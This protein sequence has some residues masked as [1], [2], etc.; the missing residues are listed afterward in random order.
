MPGIRVNR[1]TTENFRGDIFGG[2]TAAVIALPLALAFGV[3]SGAGPIAGLYGAICVGMF[4]ALF[5]GTNSQI[6]GPTGPMT[7]VAATVFTQFAGNPAMAFTVVMMSGVFQIMFGYLRIGR[8]INLMPYPVISGF[9]TGIGCILIILQLEPLIGHASPSNVVNALTVLPSDIGTPNWHAAGLG[10]LSLVVC[11]AV[12]KRVTRIFPAPLLAIISCTVIALFL[13]NV[14]L[15]GP[16]PAG[17]PVIQIPQFDYAQLSYM[18][19]SA[20]VLAAL[21]SIDS[22][23]TSLV[24][25]N[26]SRTFHD[27][28]KELVGQGVGNLVAGLAGGIPGAG[29]TV[30]TLANLKAGGRTPVSGVFHALVLLLIALGL[31]PVV[32]LIP[33]AALAGILLKVG[34]DVIDWRF[35]KRWHR[36]PRTD[37]I[38]MLVVLVLTVF[39]DVI[40]AVGVGVVMASLVFVKE[41][42][43]VQVQSI[44]TIM[45]D[46]GADLLAPDETDAF[47][48]CNGRA[49]ILHLSGAMSFGAANEMMRR[50]VSVKDVDV[51]IIDL[52]D[53]P[54]VDGSAAL[55]L[56]EIIQRAV[57]SDQEVFVVGMQFSVVR[58]LSRLGALDGV[59]DATRFSTRIEAIQAA[60][61]SLSD[62]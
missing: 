18:L 24:A 40:T 13:T 41:M 3:A 22:L 32:T 12:P 16:V 19:V 9:M 1:L 46:A 29:A 61:Q 57:D 52:A 4:A 39:V 62:R 56:E 53:V 30:R 6:S 33:H 8:Y 60:I 34:I 48:Q 36:A 7:I 54:S 2:A 11:V 35:I 37:L 49:A 25:D 55:T 50:I 45:D 44:R 31:G 10:I 5:G 42:A 26:M 38:L 23:L 51:L 21:G 15:L 17:L 28:D 43:D 59:R 58:V 47:R 20:V 27:S 14:P